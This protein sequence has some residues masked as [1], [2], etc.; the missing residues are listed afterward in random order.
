MSEVS[1]SI[2]LSTK[3]KNNVARE[4]TAFDDDFISYINA[5]LAELNQLG[6]GPAEGLQIE[7]ETTLWT[8]FYEDPRLNAVQAFV[9]LRVRLLFDPPATSFAI[10]M[11]EDQLREMGWRLV[12]AQEDIEREEEAV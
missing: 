6:I 2:L 9:G 5:A 12:V 3:K 8:E 7:D 4:Y 11:M 10:S 1:E